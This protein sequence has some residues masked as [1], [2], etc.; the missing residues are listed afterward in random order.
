M[1][2]S[3]TPVAILVLA[4]C[5]AGFSATAAVILNTEVMKVERF[6]D[7][8]GEEQ[9]RLLQV[10]EILPGDELRY[11]IRFSNNGD[12]TIVA[13]SVVI[14]NAIPDNT[15]YLAGT[16]TGASVRITYS[17][18][19]GNSFG[20]PESLKVVRDGRKVSASAADYTTLRWTF[21]PELKPSEQS[22]VSFNVRLK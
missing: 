22:Y 16:A 9:T 11:T 15:L 14:T 20:L 10:Q 4:F 1:K 7:D 5:L 17:I 13:G 6:I 8:N 3:I 12:R 18:D 21:K 2:I 19:G